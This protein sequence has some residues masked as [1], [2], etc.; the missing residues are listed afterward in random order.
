MFCLFKNKQSRNY[1]YFHFNMYRNLQS[2]I[3]FVN[4]KEKY[5]SI[6]QLQFLV[7]SHSVLQRSGS[8]SCA[9]YL[10][11]QM[12][13]FQLFK[14]VFAFKARLHLFSLPQPIYITIY[15]MVNWTPVQIFAT[16]AFCNRIEGCVGRLLLLSKL[17][18][19]PPSTDLVTIMT[20]SLCD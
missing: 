13:V 16:F 1:A 3:L 6:S 11:K 14:I 4:G 5:F 15:F 19:T 2:Q 18:R 17:I 9:K 12:L 10:Q 8:S 7:G 20:E